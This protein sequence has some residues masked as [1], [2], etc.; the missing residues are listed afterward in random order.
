[1]G[2]IW[3]HN[4]DLCATRDPGEQSDRVLDVAVKD[5]IACLRKP[6]GTPGYRRTRAV[7]VLE[8]AGRSAERML[9]R[10]T[11]S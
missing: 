8:R 9:G 11:A 4:V 5:A 6:V 7:L 10:R 3:Q 2:T 1:M